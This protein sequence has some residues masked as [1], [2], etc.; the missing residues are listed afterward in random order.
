MGNKLPREEG[1]TLYNTRPRAMLMSKNEPEWS[2][3][4]SVL[5]CSDRFNEFEY[6]VNNNYKNNNNLCCH[7][8]KIAV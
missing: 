5:N 3:E 1:S 7:V 8:S 4:R 6:N 2:L